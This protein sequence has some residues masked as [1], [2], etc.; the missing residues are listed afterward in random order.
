M[1]IRQSFVSN[2]STCSFVVLGYEIPKEQLNL[3][4][5]YEQLFDEKPDEILLESEG[6]LLMDISEEFSSKGYELI[7][8]VE[9][10]APN[11]NTVLF[12]VGSRVEEGDYEVLNVQEQ[13]NNL[14]AMMRLLD[15]EGGD[16]KMITGTQM[17]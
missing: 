6:E 12:G 10:G 1:K 3:K 11:D 15:L 13:L 8:N 16:L 2:S 5:I 9:E 4:N 7:T 17:C 14:N